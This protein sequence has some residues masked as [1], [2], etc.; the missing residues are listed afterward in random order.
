MIALAKTITYA[1]A[2][3]GMTG[4][5]IT[6]AL[7]GDVQTRTIA[8]QTSDV[9]LATAKGQK[10]LEQRVAKAVRSVCRT[11]SLTTGSRMMDQDAMECLAKARIDAK[12]Q[13]AALTLEQQRG[14]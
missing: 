10:I 11:A 14:G 7:A 4:A 12:Q 9:D 5:A 8:V 1:L 3:I 2:A 6:P 13:M